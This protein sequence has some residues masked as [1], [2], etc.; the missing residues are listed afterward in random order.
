MLKMQTKTFAETYLLTPDTAHPLKPSVPLNSSH[1]KIQYHVLM[2][3]LHDQVSSKLYEASI[4]S[5]DHKP[6]ITCPHNE[7]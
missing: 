2:A 6:E 5:S 3:H 7:I 4:H 1:K